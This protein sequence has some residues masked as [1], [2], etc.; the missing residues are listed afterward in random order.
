[1]Y[2]DLGAEKVIAAEKAGLKIAVEIKSFVGLSEMDE[3]ENALGKY[4]VYRSVMARVEPD[5][6]LYLAIHD[7]VFYD[8]FDQPLGHILIEDY[9]L[10][11]IVYDL[12][13]EVVLQWIP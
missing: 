10:Q 8:V 4:L 6:T 2:V 9:Q 7:E 12:Q 5:R 13:K 3:I 1:M 11:L